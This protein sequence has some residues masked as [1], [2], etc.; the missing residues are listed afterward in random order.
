[1]ELRNLWVSWWILVIF[2]A[3][4]CDDD[5]GRAVNGDVL[6]DGP[7]LDLCAPDCNS[8]TCGDDGCGGSCGRC[9]NLEGEAAPQLCVQGQCC[10]PRCTGMQCG[11]DGCGGSCGTCFD[12]AGRPEPGLCI[13]GYC[14]EPS[15]Q[16]KDCGGDGCGGTCGECTAPQECST[17][18]LC[19]A[20]CVPSCEGCCGDDGCGGDCTGSCDVAERCDPFACGCVE[21][22][23]CG[24]FNF[25]V[26]Q[27]V[28]PAPTTSDG[29]AGFVFQNSAALVCGEAWDFT[30]LDVAFADNAVF[31]FG[32]V[33]G[34]EELGPL[35]AALFGHLVRAGEVEGV[36]LEI[37]MDLTGPI[38]TYIETGQ[39]PLLDTYYFDLYPNAFFFRAIL[40]EA[41]ALYLEG[42]PVRGFGAE[43][44]YRVGWVNEELEAF[45]NQL[46]TPTARAL[47]L[48][49]LPPVLG[50]WDP[51]SQAFTNQPTPTGS[52]SSRTWTRS[53]A[54]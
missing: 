39:G 12:R 51:V 28:S 2:G 20:P 6:A 5:L 29:I 36:G 34:S 15:C 35:S 54:S 8:R 45:A 49:T 37:G 7:E 18:G 3:F 47:V 11:D 13:D 46:A 42:Y 1:M 38:N 43:V 44:P 26:C 27:S 41:R 32:E 53:A 16:G 31:M 40:D 50:L 30:A 22:P 10:A 14:C 48:D 52:T 33:H 9:F 24:A 23:A 4:G 21:L 19:E 17:A 25:P